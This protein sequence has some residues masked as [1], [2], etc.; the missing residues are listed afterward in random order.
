MNLQVK[1]TNPYSILPRYATAGVAAMEGGFGGGVN[2]GLQNIAEANQLSGAAFATG[3]AGVAL[4]L[5]F[6]VAGA[7][8]AGGAA[9]LSNSPAIESGNKCCNSH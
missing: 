5:G 7:A 3:A 6:T 4:G 1:R 8:I 9:A 2:M